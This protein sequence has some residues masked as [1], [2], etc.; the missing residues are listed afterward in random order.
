MTWHGGCKIPNIISANQALK[1]KNIFPF[2][3]MFLC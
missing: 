3:P 1:P 2:S